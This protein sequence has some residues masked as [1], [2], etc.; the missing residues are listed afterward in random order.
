MNRLIS[1]HLQDRLPWA[2][3]VDCT[4]RLELDF[5]FAASRR[6]CGA[7]DESLEMKPS[8]AQ[9]G[10]KLL[11]SVEHRSGTASIEVSAG[12]HRGDQG[13]EIEGTVCLR[14]VEVI[15]EAPRQGAKEFVEGCPLARAHH[16]ENLEV[17]LTR[18]EMLG[19]GI[20]RRSPD[21]SSKQRLPV[22]S[23]LQW[24]IVARPPYLHKRALLQQMHRPRPAPPL[25]FEF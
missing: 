22:G 7:C 13:C 23:R 5:E 17:R 2:H 1:E 18:R 6:L 9:Q 20:D 8:P 19:H 25:G 10:R 21:T 4:R 16:V 14:T 12:R 15:G 24:E 11:Q 3:P